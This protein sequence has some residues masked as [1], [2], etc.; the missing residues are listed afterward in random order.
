ML[1]RTTGVLL[2]IFAGALLFAQTD[3]AVLRGVVKDSSGAFVPNAQVTVTET[4]TNI[5]A[6]SLITDA[7]GNYEAPDL[8]Q[9]GRAH[10]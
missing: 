5:Q 6:R 3:R 4:E 10:V 7:N 8:K 1:C 2:C 9:I